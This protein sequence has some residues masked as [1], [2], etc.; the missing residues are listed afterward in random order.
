[1][2]VLNLYTLFG[3]SSASL[4]G[5]TKISLSMECL[6]KKGWFYISGLYRRLH[7]RYHVEKMKNFLYYRLRNHS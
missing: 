5:V 7:G 2:V 3:V 6:S 4:G 1:M